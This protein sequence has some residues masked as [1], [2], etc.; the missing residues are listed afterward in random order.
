MCPPVVK[1]FGKDNVIFAVCFRARNFTVSPGHIRTG[2]LMQ[3][4][5][6]PRAWLLLPR[7]GV[8]AAYQPLLAEEFA[9]KCGPTPTPQV[10]NPAFFASAAPGT[11]NHANVHWFQLD[12]EPLWVPQ[13]WGPSFSTG[14]GR[15]SRAGF[16]KQM[17]PAPFNLVRSIAFVKV[18]GRP[19]TDLGPFCVGSQEGK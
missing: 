1:T 13:Y 15:W 5:S 16:K 18:D 7:W 6:H 17:P 9:F 2:E 3:N 19:V 10:N 14:W 8:E 12:L 4:Q 11:Y